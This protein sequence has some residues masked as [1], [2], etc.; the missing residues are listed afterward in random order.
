[1]NRKALTLMLLFAIASFLFCGIFVQS[2]KSQFL[3]S[4]YISDDG[5]VVGTDTIQRNGNIY[6]LTANIS[7]GIQ[8]QKSNIVIDGASYTV[9]GNGAG[10]GLDL[11]NSVGEDPA[12]ST[13]SNVTLKNLRIMDFG[14]G[15]ATNGGGNYTFYNIYVAN[16]GDACINLVACSNNTIKYCTIE[17]NSISMVY[18]ANY[19]TV[20][21]NNFLNSNVIVWLSGYETIDRNYW[22]DYNGTDADGD[23]IGDTPIGH[24]SAIL[25]NHPFMKPVTISEL[26]T[27]TENTIFIRV[28]GSIE[29]TDKIHRSENL[30]AFTE[31]LFGPIVVERDNI[32]LNG[33][34]YTLQGDGSENG[35]TFADISNTTVKSLKLSNFNIG[36][37]VMGS[38]DNKI[39]ENTITDCFRGLD[40]TASENNTVSKNYIA[41]N[42]DGIA[43]ENMYNN[44]F[45]NT[46]TNNS[47]VGIFL[48][49]AGYNNITGNNI[50][51][52]S[53]GILVHICYNNVIHHD[54]FVNNGNHVE[55]DDSNNIWDNGEEGNY[56]DNYTGLDSDEDGVGDTPYV[57]D[58][59]NRDNYPLVEQIPVSETEPFPTLL[60]IVVIVTAGAVAALGLLAYFKKRKR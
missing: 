8:V 23:G 10:R 1:M 33:A 41:N 2:A 7:G 9:Q 22:S 18:Q 31:D 16:C 27:E 14:F 28:D 58:E 54:N 55:T 6:T 32:V 56:W 5:A 51:N 29:G 57:I 40:L 13:I 17:G 26:S 39:L 24:P 43:L 34:G 52:N 15:I 59:N 19:N 25:D 48:N 36:I 12:R 44:I 11:S 38:D 37:V 30:Y 4:V 50:T 21:K 3:G 53:R 35:I 49:G 45:D 47:D 46:I 20:T 60:V 42:N